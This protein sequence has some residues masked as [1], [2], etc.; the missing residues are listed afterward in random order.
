MKLYN[1]YFRDIIKPI[2]FC[3]PNLIWISYAAIIVSKIEL[4]RYV[5]VELLNSLDPTIFLST[6]NVLFVVVFLY[7]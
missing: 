6:K 2:F 7:S 5:Y 3:N 1:I 4:T